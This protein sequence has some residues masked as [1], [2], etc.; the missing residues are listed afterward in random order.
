[1]DFA[2][3]VIY[4]QPGT[5]AEPVRFAFPRHSA[6]GANDGNL[7]FGFEPNGVTIRV[8]DLATGEDLDAEATELLLANVALGEDAEDAVVVDVDLSYPGFDGQ[9]Q[10]EFRLTDGLRVLPRDYRLVVCGER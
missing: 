7:P 5:T 9:Y 1:M 10:L 2:Y 4:V 8:T 6:V 3:A